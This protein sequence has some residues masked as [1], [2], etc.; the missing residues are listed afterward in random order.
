[1]TQL[2][3]TPNSPSQVPVLSSPVRANSIRRLQRLRRA[4]TT[5][6]IGLFILVFHVLVAITGPLW[7]PFTYNKVGT[8]KPFEGVSTTH[9]FGTD[10]LGRDVFSRVV[11]GTPTVLLLSIS[12]TAL[13]LVIGSVLGLLSGYLRG[14]FDEVLM[15]IF[16]AFIS[17]PF[18][19]LALLI[20]SA[21]G[22]EL[23]GNPLL[24]IGVVAFIYAPRIAR[25][26][27]AVALDLVTR[28]FVTVARARGESAWSIVRRELLP[29]AT[30]TLL[31]EFAVRAGYAPI[32]I[33]SLG[34]LG[35]GARPPS[36]EW[37]LMISENRSAI[38][39]SP[40]TVIGP[41]LA[42]ASLVI[43]LNLF[44]DGL[45]RMLGRSAQ[46]SADP[47]RGRRRQAKVES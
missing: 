16:D 10:Q 46:F 11:Y 25:M 21:A 41:S 1:M 33:G 38:T 45:A 4:P 47:G 35:F 5:F 2:A 18:L 39:T 13:G 27:R 43:G 8:G 31:V 9:L 15:R 12:G 28:D 32:L 26:T 22:S 37:G 34:F 24:L 40:I 30:G 29:N 20:I 19:I 23:A 44:S 36:P 42:L 14:W 17:I 3:D 6:K 7:A